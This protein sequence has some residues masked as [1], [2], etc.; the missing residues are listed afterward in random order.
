M[1]RAAFAVLAVAIA[2]APGAAAANFVL[3]T[4][5]H[6]RV[7]CHFDDEK[8]ADAALETAE[9]IWPLASELYGLSAAP[10]DPPLDVHLYRRAADYLAAEREIGLG[11]FDKNLAFSSYETRSAYVAVQPDLTDEALAEAGITAQT[12]HLLAHEAAH[13]VRW[14]AAPAFRSHPDW[15]SD[16]AAIWIEEETLA[17]RG[18]S[19]GGGE[20]PYVASDMIRAQRLLAGGHLPSAAGVLRDE[21][22][23]MDM[24]DRYAIRK[25]LFRRLVTRNDAPAFRAALLAAWKLEDGPDFAKRFQETVLAPYAAEGLAGLDLDFEQFVRS[26][27]PA[28]DE[29]FRSLATAGDAWL[30]AAFADRNAVAWRTSPVGSDAYE[31]RGQVEILPGSGRSQQM[32]L[33]L[34]RAA[35]GFVSVSFVAGYGADVFRF[36]AADDRWERIAVAP[37]KAVQL[38]R[39]VPVRV[40]VDG[41]KLTLRIDGT[42]VAT[43]DV[44]GHPMSGPWGLGVQ[45]GAAGVWRGIRVEK[46]AAKAK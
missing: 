32:N 43:A 4:G 8:A 17:S 23:D 15:L 45:A 35:D 40:T 13:L 29:V 46:A 26:Q 38:W 16:G 28:W 24:Y 6:F 30:Q 18:W 3:R 1:R 21:T 14:R 5:P 31:V 34:C 7:L 12:R 19:A 9:A 41:S 36:H 22:K 10:L 37:T 25:L 27:T 2:A 42:D 39:R 33:L 11:Q 20:D 44:Q